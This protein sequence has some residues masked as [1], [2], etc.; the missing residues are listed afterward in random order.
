[1]RKSWHARKTAT[2]ILSRLGVP[3]NARVRWKNTNALKNVGKPNHST[4]PGHSTSGIDMSA[5]PTRIH[6]AVEMFLSPLV[7]SVAPSEKLNTI[8][9]ETRSRSIRS[10]P[11]AGT[12]AVMC[13]NQLQMNNR[14]NANA[15]PFILR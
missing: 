8:S 1:M 13:R 7:F 9:T 10:A 3:T 11:S 2:S 15:R 4:L 6:K 5:Y 12:R 14:Y